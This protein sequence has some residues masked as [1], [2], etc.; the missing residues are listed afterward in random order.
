MSMNDV[1]GKLA[2]ER[3]RVYLAQLSA[4]SYL[5]E[6]I[7]DEAELEADTVS[8]LIRGIY[9]DLELLER[10]INSSKS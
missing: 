2:L 6:G 5:S 3:C 8:H 10:S 4:A 9:S 1:Y 7:R